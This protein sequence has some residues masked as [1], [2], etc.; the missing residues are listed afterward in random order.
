MRPQ[1]FSWL[2]DDKTAWERSLADPRYSYDLPMDNFMALYGI[3]RK[4]KAVIAVSQP[5]MSIPVM[6]NIQ[7][8]PVNVPLNVPVSMPV[9]AASAPKE[10]S[11]LGEGILSQDEID[12]L[13]SSL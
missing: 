8:S 9:E 12:A 6:S 2:F 10:E 1:Y 7:A 11:K 4:E 13:L 3:S 5:I